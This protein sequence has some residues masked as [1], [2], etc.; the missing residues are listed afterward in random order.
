MAAV[1]LLFVIAV[2]GTALVW[3]ALRQVCPSW[4]SMRASVGRWASFSV[5]MD[6]RQGD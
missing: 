6:G 5:E 2:M 1:V 4:F 3:L